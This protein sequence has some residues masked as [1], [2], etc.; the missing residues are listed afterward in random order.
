MAKRNCMQSGVLLAE[1]AEES[2]PT[3]L[4]PQLRPSQSPCTPQWAG[5]A[6]KADGSTPPPQK[7]AMASKSS[8]PCR[9]IPLHCSCPSHFS[10][11]HSSGMIAADIVI[12]HCEQPVISVPHR[13]SRAVAAGP[14]APIP[15]H[16]NQH[17]HFGAPHSSRSV[18]AGPVASLPYIDL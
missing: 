15:L 17:S 16:C 11:H 8:W 4:V 14:V 18:T 7:P 5:K 12:S 10:A 9:P 6:S 3:R 1:G 2:S 13:L